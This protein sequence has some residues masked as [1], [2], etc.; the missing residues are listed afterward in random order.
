MKIQWSTVIAVIVALVIVF[1]A[2]LFFTKRTVTPSG[3]VV[4]KFSGFS[5]K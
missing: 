2:W 5:G 1:G 4:T 3:Q